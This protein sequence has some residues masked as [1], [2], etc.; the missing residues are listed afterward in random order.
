MIKKVTITGADDTVSVYD[1]HKL[2]AAFPFVEWGILLSAKRHGTP[3]YPSKEFL[4]S[5]ARDWETKSMRPEN[6]EWKPL[7][8][9]LSLHLCGRYVREFLMGIFT[10]IDDIGVDV[11]AAFQRVQINTH[12]ELHEFNE[13]QLAKFIMVNPGKQFIFQYD[14]TNQKLLE[15]IAGLTNV[16]VLHD[17]SSGAGILPT[18]WPEPFLNVDC[19][20]A[21]GLSPAN[22]YEQINKILAVTGDKHIWIDM[23]THVRSYDGRDFF[24]LEKVHAC[25][26]V[27][28]QYVIPMDNPAL[29][30]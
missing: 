18:H 25:L 16:A 29:T 10:F 21:G 28:Q 2:T 22:L 3:R 4:K 15:F 7:N 30:A 13:K 1:L 26:K 24:D 20:Y 12:G 8:A 14:G 23:E 6:T 17:L 19:G 9:Q 11:W 27:A 5:I